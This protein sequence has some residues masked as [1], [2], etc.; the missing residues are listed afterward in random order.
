MEKISGCIIAMNEEEE[1]ARAIGNLRKFCDE[2]VVV[3]GGSGDGTVEVAKKAGVTVLKNKWKD[4]FSAQRNF[5][6]RKA[7]FDWIFMLDA[8]EEV[9]PALGKKIKELIKQKNCKGFFIPRKNYIDGALVESDAKLEMQPRLFIKTQ[10][11]V[12]AIH[13][14]PMASDEFAM[15]DFGRDEYIIHNKSSE[16]QRKHLIYQKEII[17]KSL[18][19]AI[20]K[21][22]KA[23]EKRMRN[24]LKKW[25]VWWHDAN[26]R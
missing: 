5:A 9:T 23:E 11:Y 19:E 25:E 13:E 1:I 22:D 21:D 20:D 4:D 12:S 7:K 15:S 6:I 14:R 18:K 26:G 3:D 10:R 17:K 24:A 8:D 2:V 16:I